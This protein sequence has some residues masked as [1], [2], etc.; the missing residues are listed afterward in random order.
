[1][2]K[3]PNIPQALESL[4][5]RLREEGEAEVL[6]QVGEAQAE[7]QARLEQALAGAEEERV[8]AVK[9]VSERLVREHR[10]E[11]E[12]L[13]SRF[14]MVH[15]SQMERSPSDTSLEKIEVRLL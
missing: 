5:T 9:E 7:A 3:V 10:M 12:G 2:L 8:A 15:A 14:R 6:R 4:G 13:R 1:M 11:M